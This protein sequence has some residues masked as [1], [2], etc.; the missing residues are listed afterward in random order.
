MI[1]SDGA[2]QFNVLVH[3]LCWVHAERALRRLQ[4]NTSQ[5]RQ[6]HRGDATAALA[7]LSAVKDL[8]PNPHR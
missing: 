6:K 5:Q 1:L 3:A 8:P 2:P 4:G 7:L